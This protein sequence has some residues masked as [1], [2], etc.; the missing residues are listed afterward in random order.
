MTY[1]LELITRS[2]ESSSNEA[3]L[4]SSNGERCECNRDT[5]S[6][7][8]LGA[9]WIMSAIMLCLILPFYQKLQVH[10]QF[11]RAQ[12]HLTLTET[13]HKKFQAFDQLQDAGFRMVCGCGSGTN[14]SGEIKPGMDSEENK[15]NHYNEFVFCRPWM[16]LQVTR[17]LICHV[18]AFEATE[19]LLVC[20]SQV[21]NSQIVL[22]LFPQTNANDLSRIARKNPYFC[23]CHL[24]NSVNRKAISHLRLA[25]HF[26]PGIVQGIMSY[27][28]SRTI[29]TAINTLQL[30]GSILYKNG[31]S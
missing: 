2:S 26:E 9:Q 31:N 17:F 4:W 29:R 13:L 23:Y 14:S 18:F 20:L 28:P 8:W 21:N 12:F 30:N 16:N 1:S 6:R 10:C 11:S 25:V 22:L 5:S 19:Q 27:E 24:W 3:W 15:W 7:V